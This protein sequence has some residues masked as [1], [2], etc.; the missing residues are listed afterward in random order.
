MAGG[1]GAGIAGQ[2]GGAGQGGVSGQGGGASAAGGGGGAG[3]AGGGGG[4]AGGS[5][6]GGG[7]GS[8]TA[9][10]GGSARDGGVD[11]PADPDIV[12]QYLGPV[13]SFGA[14]VAVD[15]ANVIHVAVNT[16]SN[17][18]ATHL[19]LDE[20][21]NFIGQ[22]SDPLAG[23][24]AYQAIAID[25]SDDVYFAGTAGNASGYVRWG[26]VGGTSWGHTELYTTT[27]HAG[28]RDAKIDSQGRLV[29]VG[30]SYT[31]TGYTAILRRYLP[32]G[33]YDL[34]KYDSGAN[35]DTVG[36]AVGAND[37]IYIAGRNE[38]ANSGGIYAST[39]TFTGWTAAGV[40]LFTVLFA[41]K[42]SCQM[43]G[44]YTNGWSTT[45]DGAGGLWFLGEQCDYQPILRKYD[46][47]T[48]TLLINADYVVSG[49]GNESRVAS[50][51]TSLC[52]VGYGSWSSALPS[53]FQVY[54]A[55]LQG[56][57]LRKFQYHLLDDPELSSV[58]FI[59]HDRIVVGGTRLATSTQYQVWVARLRAP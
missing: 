12:W 28:W 39:G 19:R 23:G 45:V 59:G 58:A 57:P 30:E 51:G 7:A 24:T 9:G 55:D 43:T 18:V 46:P 50:D 15:S 31:S 48:G 8:A 44:S 41:N 1:G 26:G 2:G 21:G 25:A 49:I 10:A 47:A 11:A 32:A 52:A 35:D 4:Q 13:G 22:D 37:A 20:N 14:A 53:G 56:N 34:S 5:G 29:A 38:I 3:A 17:Y 42:S 33:G 6:Q 40:N 54:D 36:V 16:Q 27:G